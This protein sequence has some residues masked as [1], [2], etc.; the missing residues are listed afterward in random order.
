MEKPDPLREFFQMQ[1]V[2]DE[3][4]DARKSQVDFKRLDS[5]CTKKEETNTKPV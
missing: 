5:G 4:L 3:H 2:L 1:T